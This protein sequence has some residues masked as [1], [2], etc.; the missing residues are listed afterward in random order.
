MNE[1]SIDIQNIYE[2]QFKLKKGTEILILVLNL[3]NLLQLLRSTLKSRNNLLFFRGWVGDFIHRR[4]VIKTRRFRRRLCFRFQ[5]RE[6]SLTGGPLR[7][8]YSQY[9]GKVKWSRYRP[10]VAQRVGKII[11]LLF[12]DRGTRRG[13]V[14]SS[15]PRLHFNPGK[16]RYPF[17]RRLGGPQD[18]SGRPENLVPTGIRSRT[19]QPVVSRY[20]DWATRPTVLNIRQN[21]NVLEW[22]WQMKLD[23]HF[24]WTSWPLKMGPIVCPET[25]VRNCQSTLRN[26]PEERRSHLHRSESLKTFI[27]TNEN[28]IH[29][30][31]KN[32]WKCEG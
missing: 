16:T 30:V 21:L 28:Q 10:G 13:W 17:Y 9:Y 15:T 3:S 32:R 24:C 4:L 27:A 14:V 2:K 11:T 20:T 6:T 12:H 31:I 19:V 7:T 23:L 1:W 22:Q 25:S 29:D 8:S 26:N 18:R 5:V